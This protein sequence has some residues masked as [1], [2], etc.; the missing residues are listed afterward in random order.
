VYNGHFEFG[1]KQ[2]KGKITWKNDGTTYE[3]DFFE[4]LM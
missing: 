1:L 4:G 2:G 3:G